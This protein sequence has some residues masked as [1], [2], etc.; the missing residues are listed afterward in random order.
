MSP[1]DHDAPAA[2][3]PSELTH[4]L[5]RVLHET[6][7]RYQRDVTL[8][9]QL[10]HMTP[11]S[12]EFQECLSHWI[13]IDP[14]SQDW[15]NHIDYFGNATR[16]LTL[17][18]PHR[19]LEVRAESVVAMRPRLERAQIDGSP[20]WET[21]RDSLRQ[22]A[23]ALTLEP[24][25][26]LYE[27]PHIECSAELAHYA[28]N[29]FRHGRPVLEAAFDLTERIFRDFEF[30]HTATTIATPLS[31]VLQGRR[32]VC[33]DF[34][35]LMIGCLRTLGLAA[36]YVSGY[37]LTTPPPG[38]ARLVGADASHAWVSVY[39]PDFG[40]VDFDPTNRCLVQDEHITLGWGR[41]FSDV[42]PMRG[43]VLGGGEQEL[44]VRVTVSP[45]SAAPAADAGNNQRNDH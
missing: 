14:E 32:G 30:D 33:Q 27:S 19:A 6:H 23:D 8:S 17:S 18:T 37:I 12:F 16:H 29:S 25:Q 34:A 2:P 36:R 20:P 3:L 45:L 35:H 31:E 42:T 26:F 39:C 15:A 38:H 43:I 28:L 13:R 40:W 11:R 9:Q 24:F 41:D 10:L 1:L 5:Y 21:L 44:E 7:Y 4:T 22:S